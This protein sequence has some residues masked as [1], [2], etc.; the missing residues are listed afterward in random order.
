MTYQMSAGAFDEAIR[1][2]IAVGGKFARPERLNVIVFG[3]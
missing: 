3:L 2:I 1:Q